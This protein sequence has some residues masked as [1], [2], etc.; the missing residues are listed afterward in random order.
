MRLPKSLWIAITVLISLLWAA[1][2]VVG[3]IYPDRAQ[4]EL[5][6]I[7]GAIIGSLYLDVPTIK[8]K[9]K[10]TVTSKTEQGEDP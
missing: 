5:N 1:N 4:P 2:I 9:I 3:M 8:A 7:F 6:A 10:R